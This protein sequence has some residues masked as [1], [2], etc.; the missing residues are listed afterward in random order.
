MADAEVITL[1]VDLY[2]ELGLCDLEVHLTLGCP[3]CRGKYRQALLE[4]L[5]A[6]SSGLCKSCQ[7]RLERNPLRVLDC[8]NPKCQELTKEIPSIQDYICPEC[9]EHFSKVCRYLD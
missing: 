5:S 3:E 7:R 4:Y 6:D 8:K 2:K 9:H 1:A